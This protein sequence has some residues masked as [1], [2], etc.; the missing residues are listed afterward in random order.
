MQQLFR[1]QVVVEIRMLG[2]V[3]DTLVHGRVIQ[4]LAQDSR[5]AGSRKN[6]AEKDFERGGLPR[7][8]R[9]QQAED[10]A[11]LHLEVQ[12]IQSPFNPRL[13]ETPRDILL[14]AR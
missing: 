9:A 6:Q 12:G 8:I 14:S 7:P 1:R 13:P 2:E 5:R 10:F 3:T 11:R 4:F